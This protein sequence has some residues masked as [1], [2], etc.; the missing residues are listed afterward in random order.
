MTTDH[1]YAALAAAAE[2]GELTPAGTATH[3]PDAAQIGRQ[4][5]FAATGTHTTEEAT[6][7][8]LGRP[9]L[10]DS[11]ETRTW[12]VRAPAPLD[13]RASTAAKNLGITKSEYLRRAVSQQLDR[14]LEAAG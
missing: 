14:D 9:R 7:V 10:D 1:E 5:V 13:E 11:R 12:K 2:R 8:A 3:G 6:R 4:L